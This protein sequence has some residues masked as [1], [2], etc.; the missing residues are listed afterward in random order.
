MREGKQANPRYIPSVFLEAP[1]SL[2]YRREEPKQSLAILLGWRDS[3]QNSG[4]VRQLE[5]EYRA[6]DRRQLH[7]EREKDRGDREK[8]RKGG[9]TGNLQKNLLKF[10]SDYQYVHL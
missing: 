5:F 6:W 8:K 1:S 2:W 4:M 10:L 9:N 3:D 7:S